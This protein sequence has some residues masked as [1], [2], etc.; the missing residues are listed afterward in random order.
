MAELIMPSRHIPSYGS[1]YQDTVT[2]LKIMFAQTI[3]ITWTYYL[4]N[5]GSGSDGFL[6]GDQYLRLSQSL[7]S[8]VGMRLIEYK[9]GEGPKLEYDFFNEKFGKKS[10]LLHDGKPSKVMGVA[11]EPRAG[12]HGDP[13]N[14]GV[15][16]T[17]TLR[18][19]GPTQSVE[20]SHWWQ[21][22]ARREAYSYLSL[23]FGFYQ[24]DRKGNLERQI[25]P[26]ANLPRWYEVL[27][28]QPT[29]N[30]QNLIK[31]VW[32]EERRY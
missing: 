30:H 26:K 20:L 19:P 32:E 12:I 4:G 18:L 7:G 23:E 1:G 10:Q 29:H 24:T 28:N 5:N 6:Y 21:E 16:K 14:Y 3:D 2:T 31:V 9:P 25:L 22:V 27:K 17:Y 8:Q 11:E 13:V 15:P